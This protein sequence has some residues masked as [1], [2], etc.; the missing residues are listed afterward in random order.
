MEK[1][2]LSKVIQA[3]ID[4]PELPGQM[5]VAMY[6]AFKDA[7]YDT[8]ASMLRII[9]KETKKGILERITRLEED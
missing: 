7:D 8:M 2:L 6:D 5:P 4:E 3:V 1:E 9:V